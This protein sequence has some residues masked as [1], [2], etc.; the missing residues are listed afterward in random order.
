M[1]YTLPCLSAPLLAAPLP[2]SQRVQNNGTLY[3][4]VLFVKAGLPI[5]PRE[6]GYNEFML[7][8]KVHSECMR[9]LDWPLHGA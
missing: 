3:L 6:P 7:F 2:P 9:M 1:P 8:G 4:H 5:N